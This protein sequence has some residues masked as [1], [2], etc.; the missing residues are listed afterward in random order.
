MDV[1]D[2][3]ADDEAEVRATESTIV[4]DKVSSASISWPAK[5]KVVPEDDNALLSKPIESMPQPH[6]TLSRSE[7]GW[8]G[9]KWRVRIVRIFDS[10]EQWK[11]VVEL[12]FHW[13]RKQS[14]LNEDVAP[15]VDIPMT[16]PTRRRAS[17][18]KVVEGDIEMIDTPARFPH[19]KIMND[20]FSLSTEE[21]YYNSFAEPSLHFGYLSFTVTIHERLELEVI[22]TLHYL[23]LTFNSYVS[24]LI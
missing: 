14:I 5:N 24:Y 7:L 6:K 17:L 20:E 18:A 21:I 12:Y 2:F 22:N 13:N 19:F 15:H 10:E 11:G 16:Q 3:F 9:L 23:A 4:T 1:S 8:V